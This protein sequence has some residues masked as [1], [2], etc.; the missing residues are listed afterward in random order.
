[1]LQAAIHA[2][3]VVTRCFVWPGQSY[4]PAGFGSPL[5]PAGDDHALYVDCHVVRTAGVGRPGTTASR[6]QMQRSTAWPC[7]YP[8]RMRVLS[9]RAPGQRYVAGRGC[10]WLSRLLHSASA[11]DMQA[12]CIAC[13]RRKAQPDSSASV[14][15]SVACGHP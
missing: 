1:M 13:S 3:V 7:G 12:V 2:P 10:G 4:S 14:C 11:W 6:A 5:V 9:F 8:L 15:R